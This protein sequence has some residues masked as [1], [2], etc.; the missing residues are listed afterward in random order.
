LLLYDRTAEE[1]DDGAETSAVRGSDPQTGGR[2]SV[3]GRPRHRQY[4]SVRGTWRNH[5]HKGDIMV[6]DPITALWLDRSRRAELKRQF[7][8]S[9]DQLPQRAR[10]RS[11]KKWLEPAD[12]TCPPARAFVR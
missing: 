1:W 4:W 9:D 3:A 7:P 5:R 6:V 11:R 10:K 8:G 12:S 2:K